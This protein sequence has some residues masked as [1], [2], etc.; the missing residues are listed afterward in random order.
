MF[1]QK[2]QNESLSIIF[3]GLGIA[4]FI[5]Y[6]L[7]AI[8]FKSY[9][10]PLIIMAT[11]PFGI[12]GALVGHL[13]LGFDISII[14]L[15]GI[16]ALSGVVVND[17]LV[18]IVAANKLRDAGQSAYDA[19]C[20]A[21]VSRFRP[22]LLTSLTTFFGLLPMIFETS[23]QA[24]FL[25]PMAVSLGFGILFATVFMLLLIPVIYLLV[26]KFITKSLT[27]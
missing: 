11:I 22:I 14:S 16:V 8:P 21:G 18:F 2:T 5:I 26:D 23:A 6:G 24:R 4:L 17:S 25:I 3:A 19:V 13:V 10:Q 7:L 12:V 20:N 27:H 15:L 9:S 1:E